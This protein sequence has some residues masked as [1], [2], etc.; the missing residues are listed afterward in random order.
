MAANASWTYSQKES[1][2][3]QKFD[4]GMLAPVKQHHEKQNT[5]IWG[6]S[7]LLPQANQEG[8]QIPEVRA[9]S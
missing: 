4:H 9:Q 3:D 8:S 6:F 1:Q 5:Q 2:L 7:G